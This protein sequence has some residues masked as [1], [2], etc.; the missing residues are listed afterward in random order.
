LLL[1]RGQ[2]DSLYVFDRV[3]TDAERRTS[4]E[5]RLGPGRRRA[6]SPAHKP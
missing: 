3:L 1:V 4:Q 2:L 6:L 5:V